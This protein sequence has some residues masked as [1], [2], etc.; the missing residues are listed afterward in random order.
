MNFQMNNAL[1]FR[2]LALVTF[3]A[4][5]TAVIIKSELIGGAR[6]PQAHHAVVPLA[7]G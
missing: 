1:I 5:S 7:H 6:A 4:I 2:A 3:V